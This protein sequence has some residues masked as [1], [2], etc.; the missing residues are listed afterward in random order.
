MQCY[1]DRRKLGSGDSG[2]RY[3]ILTFDDIQYQCISGGPP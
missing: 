3:P 1:R 2:E